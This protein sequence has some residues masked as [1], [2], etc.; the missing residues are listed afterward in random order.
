MSLKYLLDCGFV[1]RYNTF[2]RIHG[3]N[4][5]QTVYFQREPYRKYPILNCAVYSLYSRFYVD[6]N[7]RFDFT[8]LG[9]QAGC[10][11]ACFLPVLDWN[12][13]QLVD[14]SKDVS[15]KLFDDYV[16]PRFNAMETQADLIAFEK[17]V[18][19]KSMDCDDL[20]KLYCQHQLIAPCLKAS[21]YKEA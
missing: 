5:L 2:Y 11:V 7:D 21:L 6:E 20:C 16:L 15:I 4:L 8:P 19:L 3:D 18:A 14:L 9:Y 17:Y 13:W 1:K 12:E 10:A